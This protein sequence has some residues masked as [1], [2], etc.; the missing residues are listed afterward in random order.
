MG[1]GML[2]SQKRVSPSRVIVV[3]TS[4]FSDSPW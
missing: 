1:E 3:G 2:E 4:F